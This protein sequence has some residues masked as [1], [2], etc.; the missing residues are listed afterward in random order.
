MQLKKNDLINLEIED[1]SAEGE[2]I[3]KLDGF[4]F[5]VKDD[6]QDRDRFLHHKH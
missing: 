6:A 4:T 1:M 5:F 2:G 3:G